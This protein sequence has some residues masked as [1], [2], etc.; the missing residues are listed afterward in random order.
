LEKL[1]FKGDVVFRFVSVDAADSDDIFST[2]FES[3][4]V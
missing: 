4:G 3:S 2:D 1:A